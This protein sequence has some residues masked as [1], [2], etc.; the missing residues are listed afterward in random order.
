MYLPCF[1]P[2]WQFLHQFGK[3]KN[4]V[5]LF[6][7]LFSGMFYNSKSNNRNMMLWE[8][9]FL[10]GKEVAGIS[11]VMQLVLGDYG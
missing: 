5:E 11:G 6:R 7:I 4:N 9:Q 8:E 2:I 3:N 1:T 10:K